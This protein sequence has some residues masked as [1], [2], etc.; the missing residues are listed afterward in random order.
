[1]PEVKVKTI[2]IKVMSNGAPDDMVTITR[3]QFR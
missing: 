3:Q 2:E 1:M